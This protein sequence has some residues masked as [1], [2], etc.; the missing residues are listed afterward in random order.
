MEK[1]VI[2]FGEVLWDMLPSGARIGGA[3]LNVCYHLGRN[4]IGSQIISQVGKDE[5][6]QRLWKG[7]EELGVDVSLCLQD[8]KHP[9]STVEV[10]LDEKGSPS[11]TIVDHVAWDF[12]AYDPDAAA[13]ISR[14]DAFVFGSLAARN[15]RSKETL[16]RYLDAAT[17]TVM[18]V[19]LREPFFQS[20]FILELVSRTQTLKINEDE[21]AVLGKWV[22]KDRDEQG[23]LNGLLNDFPNL[24]EIILTK[25]EKGAVYHSST[26][27]LAVDA[28][29][30]RI[31]DTI[32]SGDAFLAAFLAHK[33]KGQPV[34][35]SMEHAVVLSAFVATQEG[36]CPRYTLKD[37][38]NFK[39]TVQND[40]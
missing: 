7:M 40:G 29:P 19:N 4:G 37:I 39:N 5:L 22:G 36:A 27:Q 24:H 38:E 13:A 30:I 26:L 9:T 11:Y 18:D 21:L 2:S 34:A 25:G 12:M 28:R 3:P 17:Y 31:Q 32:G 15:P 6:G 23:M 16:M 10:A 35:V 1:S 33:I 8:D 14:A 20:E